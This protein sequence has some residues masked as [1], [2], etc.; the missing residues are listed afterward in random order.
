MKTELLA[1]LPPLLSGKMLQWEHVLRHLTMMET[2][3]LP[4]QTPKEILLSAIG[5]I[6][7][8]V[9]TSPVLQLLEPS[10]PTTVK[11]ATTQ[12]PSGVLPDQDSTEVSP[13]RREL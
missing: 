5:S 6:P 10:A 9:E 8:L 4:A 2:F 11:L 12:R 1:L 13:R 3:S 7:S